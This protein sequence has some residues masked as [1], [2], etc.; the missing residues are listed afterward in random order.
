MS[1]ISRRKFL[2]V[3]GAAVA[4]APVV[5]TVAAVAESTAAPGSGVTEIARSL[6]Q[7]NAVASASPGDHIKLRVGGITYYWL[8]K[9]H[10]QPDTEVALEI[11]R[12]NNRDS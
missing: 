4:A 5:G 2:K 9:Q 6:Q 3:M 10:L 8:A 11:S 7:T 1:S 12:P